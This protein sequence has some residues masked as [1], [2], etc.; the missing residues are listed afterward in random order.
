M[1]NCDYFEEKYIIWKNGL[2]DSDSAEHMHTHKENCE[3]CNAYNLEFSNLRTLTSTQVY[4]PS[5]NFETRLHFA[6]NKRGEKSTK[7]L[8]S[9]FSSGL[10]G[11]KVPV[12]A[13][14]AA[15]GIM[16]GILFFPVAESV[17][18]N[19]MAI[20]G[21]PEGTTRSIAE[22]V[23]VDDS[24]V[25]K[26]NAKDEGDSLNIPTSPYNSD[27]HSRMVSGQR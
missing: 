10:N 8:G 18:F 24:P 4:V 23:E 7:R 5:S 11:F 12:I 9:F 19:N 17:N 3:H 16:A 27:R 21:N 1:I 20:T 26:E 25:L 15:V 2:L 22:F 6:L 13:L 14:G